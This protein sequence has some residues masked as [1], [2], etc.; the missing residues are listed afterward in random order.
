MESPH[1]RNDGFGG[2]GIVKKCGNALG[3]GS[4]LV[5]RRSIGDEDDERIAKAVTPDLSLAGGCQA[6]RGKRL[7]K[8]RQLRKS[9]NYANLFHIFILRTI[10][11]QHETLGKRRFSFGRKIG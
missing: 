2:N 1:Q 5:D 6:E 10:R 3:H 4:P 9:L 11:G 8:K 7:D